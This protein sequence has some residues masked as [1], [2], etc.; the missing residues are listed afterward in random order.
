M[1]GKRISVVGAGPGGLSAAMILAHQGYEVEV[2]EKQEIVGGR[3]GRLDVGEFKF[4]I[5]PTFLMMPWILEEVFQRSG[6]RVEDYLD[7]RSLEPFYRLIYADGKEFLPCSDQASMEEQIERLWPGQ[8]KAFRKYMKYETK[9]FDRLFPCLSVP[10]SSAGHFARVGLVRALPYL[11]AHRSLF[12]HLGRFFDPDPLKLAFTFQAKY[13]G[14]SPWNCPATFSIISYVEHSGGVHHPIGGLNAIC[15]AMAKVVEEEGGRIHLGTPVEQVIVERGEARGLRLAGGEEVRSDAVVINADF[16]H[17]MTH[18]VE[19]RQ[20]K[21]WTPMRLSKAGLSCSILMFYFGVDKRYDIPHHNI[22]FADDYERNVREIADQLVLSEDMSFYIQNA[23]ATDDTLAPEGQSTLYVLV[24]V[25]NNRSSL[26]WDQVV[27]P[28][29]EKIL[30]AM[31][32]RAGL[33]DLRQ[34]IVAEAVHTP[35]HWER[36]LDV[37]EGAVFNLAHTVDQML[38]WRPHNEFEEFDRC[39]LVG[40]GTH[41]GSGLPTIYQSGIISSELIHQRFG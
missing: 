40:G 28:Y 7:I 22:Y 35:T 20:L 8:Y 18:L 12:R 13:L 27:G 31:E 41:P 36:N 10:Y 34:H 23:C 2:F 19:P 29:R 26:D 37:Y 24:P 30:D 17:A 5:G 15:T 21:R 3:N 38:Y 4:D 11:D 33:T 9:K 25:P 32:R 16:A 6:R 39:Y 1:S 14:M